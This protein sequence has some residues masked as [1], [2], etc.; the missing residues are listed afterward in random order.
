M[1]VSRDFLK[2]KIKNCFPFTLMNE[3]EIYDLIDHS[4]VLFFENGKMIF[5]EGSQ[6]H[7]L[8]LVLEGEVAL[9]KERGRQ[10]VAVNHKREGG[11]FGE[12]VLL[13][14]NSRLTSARAQANLMTLKTPWVYLSPVTGRMPGLRKILQIFAAT[15]KN[16]AA[17]NRE[18]LPEEAIFYFGYPYPLYTVARVSF[19]L[20]LMLGS[21]GAAL[22]LTGGDVLSS[23]WG[24]LAVGVIAA[25]FL[26]LGVRDF[27]EWR[28]NVLII[29]NRRVISN[30]IRLLKSETGT[31]TPLNSILNIQLLKPL[32][33]KIWDFGHL[34]VRTYTGDHLIPS[35]PMPGQVQALLEFLMA[36]ARK[37]SAAQEQNQFMEILSARQENRLAPDETYPG[38]DGSVSNG[39]EASLRGSAPITFRTHWLILLR[40]MALPALLLI[41]LVMTAGFLWLNAVILTWNTLPLLFFL[42]ASS[43]SLGWAIYQ[44]FDWYNDRYQIIAD[45][46]VD[47]NQKPFGR[48]ERRTASIYNIQS[49]RFERKGLAGILFN[50]G[51]VYIR[52]GDEE[53]TFDQVPD[54]AGVQKTIFHLLESSISTREQKNLTSQ[55]IRLANWL[56]TFRQFKDGEEKGKE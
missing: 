55:Q 30:D 27:L 17:G 6:A 29:T 23:L 22:L 44:F 19:S 3:G 26:A 21:L 34:S 38:V 2:V 16:L 18:D 20:L 7:H 5:K 54:P 28:K 40:K 43:I 12:E 13:A 31:D 24:I 10:T 45:Q 52:I 9:L 11:V 36:G 46:I 41:S 35:V 32:A 33:G 48:E 50:Y 37:D 25:A 49:I 1:Q 53:F 39:V 56:E 4:E 47:I 42:A 14:S 8:Y 51:T 15:Y